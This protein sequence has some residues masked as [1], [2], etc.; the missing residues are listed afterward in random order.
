MMTGIRLLIYLGVAI[1]FLGSYIIL[2]D[3]L[4]L[5]FDSY[6]TFGVFVCAIGITISFVG[7][8]GKDKANSTEIAEKTMLEDEGKDAMSYHNVAA[9]VALESTKKFRGNRAMGF[10]LMFVGIIVLAPII[11]FPVI[12]SCCNWPDVSSFIG[13]LGVIL[14]SPISLLGMICLTFGV[15]FRKLSSQ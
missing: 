2:S 13:F 1:M 15:L 6:A 4:D 9:K 10:V 5:S 7:F 14:S 8:L 11:L 12:G 3:A